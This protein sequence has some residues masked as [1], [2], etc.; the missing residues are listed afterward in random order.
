MRIS[1]FGLSLIVATNFF[2]SSST[3]AHGNTEER[4]LLEPVEE[5]VMQAGNVSIAFDLFDK[6]Q[7]KNLSDAELNI[8]HEKRLHVFLFDP[9]LKE[10]RHEHPTFNGK[11]WV[12][13]AALPRNGR[14][15]IYAQGVLSIDGEEFTSSNRIVVNAGLA[16]N[17]P[18]PLADNRK[19]ADGLSQLT[20]P[21]KKL[22]AKQAEMISL[23]ID[24]TDGSQ[25]NVTEYLGALAHVLIVSEDGDT[26]IHAHPHVMGGG[27]MI[28][29][30]FPAAGMYRVWTQFLDDG[31]LKTIPLA[32]KVE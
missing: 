1:I 21:A 25:P 11:N 4:V 17:K 19:G 18:V 31:V 13:N 12:V 20:L 2:Y 9:A 22:K 14:Y 27:P 32:V 6:K 16:A 28:H 10:Y 26:I 23:K 24:R 30:E 3:F 29:T 7:K 15:W 5:G 8:S